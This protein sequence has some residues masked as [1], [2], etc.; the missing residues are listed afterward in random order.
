MKR[1]TKETEQTVASN[2]LEQ[3]ND[4]STEKVS[5]KDINSKG[6]C[7]SS[8]VKQKASISTETASDDSEGEPAEKNQ[9]PI[10]YSPVD[11]SS[12]KITKTTTPVNTISD[13]DE[14]SEEYG[15]C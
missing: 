11:S 3:K 14:T 5:A 2:N 6:K 13:S 12:A 8:T 10:D 9:V 4:E 15:M 1:F 7:T